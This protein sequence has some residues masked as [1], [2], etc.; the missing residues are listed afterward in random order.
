MSLN[1]KELRAISE[2]E[3]GRLAAGLKRNRIYLVLEDVLDTYNIGG[4][5]RLADAIAAEK[6]Y[7][8]GGTATPPDHKIVKASVGA[9]KLVPWE[10][11]A[12]AEEALKK[13]RKIR[14]LSILAV[15]Q[16]QTAQD[17]RSVSYRLPL[18]FVF[19]HETTGIKEETLAS[20]DGVI[21]LPMHGINRSL[22][23]MVAAGIA[24]YHALEA[25]SIRPASRSS[26]W[27]IGNKSAQK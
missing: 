3:A 12:T 24:L 10:Y 14:G 21:E 20:V 25:A 11:C 19:G 16:H 9:Y 23:V 27:R 5:F 13:L 22:N 26:W 4:F 17:Y 7:L 8:C 2:A 15:E 1:S 18:A 6:V